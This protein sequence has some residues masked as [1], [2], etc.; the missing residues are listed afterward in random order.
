MGW[1]LKFDQLVVSATSWAKWALGRTVSGAAAVHAGHKN[2]T[3][4]ALLLGASVLGADT[5]YE[6]ATSVLTAVSAVYTGFKLGQ[7]TK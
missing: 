6:M 7:A 3:V 1:L 5:R 2:E 4:L